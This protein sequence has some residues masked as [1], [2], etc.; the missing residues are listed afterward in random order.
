MWMEATAA[1]I[2]VQDDACYV[3]WVEKNKLT[4]FLQKWGLLDQNGRK[5]FKNALEQ[6]A[7][8]FLRDFLARS[9]KILV[10][11]SKETGKGV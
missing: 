7:R 11:C 3:I 10:C 4:D 8:P 6:H 1:H 2:F 5:I 9:S